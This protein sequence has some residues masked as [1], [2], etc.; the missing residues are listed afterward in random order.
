MGLV[1]DMGLVPL[2][3]M[4]LVAAALAAPAVGQEEEAADWVS[5][6]VFVPPVAAADGVCPPS[7]RDLPAFAVTPVAAGPQL[8]RV[9]LPFAPGTFPAELGLAVQAGGE[10]VVPDVRP[11]TYHPGRPPSVR[12]AVITFVHE[13][14]DTAKQGFRLTLR[15]HEVD[16]SP[17][18]IRPGAFR[19]HVGDL[20][21]HA[22]D[23]GVEIG[24]QGQTTWR[25]EPV[26]PSRAWSMPR[27]TSSPATY[28]PNANSFAKQLSPTTQGFFR[29]Q[30][31]RS[32]LVA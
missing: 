28:A 18:P 14:P 25:L 13:F 26:A 16:P 8:V 21:V 19:G 24:R 23:S 29:S 4:A 32:I 7:S 15:P 11:L 5:R 20:D 22:T 1:R 30:G 12:R 27:N 10:E 9:S 17:V 6:F 3:V 31:Q 2:G